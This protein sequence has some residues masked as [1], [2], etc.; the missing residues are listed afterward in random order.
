MNKDKFKLS[1]NRELVKKQL[2]TFALELLDTFDLTP[3]KAR[4]RSRTLAKK[5]R[6][7][8]HQLLSK[9]GE[10]KTGGSQRNGSLKIDQYIS[11]RLGD[12]IFALAAVQCKD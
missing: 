4:E 3:S 8:P 2:K 1:V 7:Q 9:N 12:D 10:P 11:Y 5:Y 6:F